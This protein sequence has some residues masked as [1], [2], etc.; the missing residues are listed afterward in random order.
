MSEEPETNKQNELQR[1]EVEVAALREQRERANLQI[2]KLRLEAR[3]LSDEIFEREEH[4]ATLRAIEKAAA[5]NAARVKNRRR[6][7]KR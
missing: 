3:R 2:E 4:A 1:I 6:A 5:K 7:P